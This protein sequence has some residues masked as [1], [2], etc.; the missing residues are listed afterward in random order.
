M[1]AFADEPERQIIGVVG[2]IR[3]GRLNTDPQP[4]M[5]VPQGQLADAA[6]ALNLEISSMGWIVRTRSGPMAMSE[7]I[8]REL[9]RATGIPVSDASTMDDV[10]YGSTARERFS[11]LLMSIFGAAALLLAAI[12]VYGLMA[13][14]V[15]QRTQEIGI[16]LA[17]GAATGQVWNMVVAQG[18]RLVV[19]GVLIGLAAASGLTRFIA[20]FLF[21]V[22]PWDPL[23]FI[24]VPV[25]LALVAMVAVIVPARR[26]SQI[27]PILALRSD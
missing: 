23:A 21:Q 25:V 19:F 13:Y 14:S 27:N 4:R 2:D 18:M 12:G 24:L 5:Y 20:S 16:R 10:V 7:A 26:A 1:Q 8:Q 6:N 3:D 15:E 22:E 11:M 9:E 17:L